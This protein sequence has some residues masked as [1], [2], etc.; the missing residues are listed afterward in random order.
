MQQNDGVATGAHGD[1][2]GQQDGVIWSLASTDVQDLLMRFQNPR[3]MDVGGVA[4]GGAEGL[5]PSADGCGSGSGNG[6]GDFGG[7]RGASVVTRSAAQF[8]MPHG[9]SSPGQV[10]SGVE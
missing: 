7:D 8:L 5:Q 2:Q 10:G 4:L 9:D 3:D 6:G 1:T